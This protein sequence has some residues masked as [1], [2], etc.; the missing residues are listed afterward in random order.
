[1]PNRRDWI[2]LIV[3]FLLSL[4]TRWY[5][6]AETMVFTYDQ[7]RDFYVWQE[8]TRGKPTL[9]GPTTGLQGVFLG[10]FFYY[11]LWPAFVVG[12]GNPVVVAAWVGLISSLTLPF[13]YLILRKFIDWR[14]A[15]L[16]YLWLILAP[17]SIE[18]GR[19]IWN[20]SLVVPTFLF[21][22]WLL[23][24]SKQKAWL[25]IPAALG[26]ALSLQTELAYTFFW[27]P[28]VV[29][30]IGWQWWQKQY[31][32]KLVIAALCAGLLTFAPQILF[33]LRHDFLITHS[34]VANFSNQTEHVSL[35]TTW[36]TR[37]TLMIAEMQR[38]LTHQT[39]GQEWLIVVCLLWAVYLATKPQ[40]TAFVRFIAG[41]TLIPL[42]A[43]LLFTG[44]GGRFFD[45][46]ITSHFALLILST[47]LGVG[48]VLSFSSKPKQ[49]SIVSGV[50]LL[51]VLSIFLRKV[52]PL[53]DPRVYTYTLASQIQALQAARQLAKTHN[54]PTEST[55]L[56][57][58][59][60]NLLPVAYQYLSEW[61]SRT[62]QAEPMP[63]GSSRAQTDTS[64]TTQGY[65]R[66]Y[67]P[68][69]GGASEIIFEDWAKQ[70][71]NCEMEQTYGI[72]RVAWCQ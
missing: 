51:L 53:Y 32:S 57:V 2:I 17:A 59:V 27:G 31:S 68:A 69:F 28:A 62:Q 54:Q 40:T 42:L 23:L 5:Q 12:N 61:L 64:A 60:P 26:F 65:V 3:G 72:T 19:H 16:G 63:F 15:T 33:E 47:I 48:S 10:P 4:I 67:E 41:C 37:P 44:N 30:W 9:I 29:A 38:S 36:K 50:I 24:Q 58:F 13:G 35:A 71:A 66:I 46:Y 25:I 70:H 56:E 39:I 20:P 18:Q 49:A 8:L 6:L 1:M 45:Y 52:I 22:A 7:G 14:W 43:F 21:S 11:A 34:I 55:A